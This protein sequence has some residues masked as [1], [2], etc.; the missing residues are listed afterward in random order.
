MRRRAAGA[1]QRLQRGRRL[2]RGRGSQAADGAARAGSGGFGRAALPAAGGCGAGR[3]T[4]RAAPD[5][6]CRRG[7]AGCRRRALGGLLRIA[8]RGAAGDDRRH[9]GARQDDDRRDGQEEAIGT[10]RR[11]D[12]IHESLHAMAET[13]AAIESAGNRHGK[14]GVLA[15]R[16]RRDVDQRTGQ[17]QRAGRCGD[18]EVVTQ[19]LGEVLE[20]APRPGVERLHGRERLDAAD[21]QDPRGIAPCHVR[22]LVRAQRQLLRPG[23]SRRGRAWAGTPRAAAGPWRAAPRDAAPRS[24]APTGGCRASRP[25]PRPRPRARRP[26]SGSGRGAGAAAARAATTSR[27]RPTRAAAAQPIARTVR[28]ARATRRTPERGRR[29]SRGQRGS[30]AGQALEARRA[31]ARR[32]AVPARRARRRRR[33]DARPIAD[34]ARRLP[35]ASASGK[36]CQRRP[37][38]G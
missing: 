23:P 33:R 6:G 9:E 2:R 25:R 18:G 37:G 7:S 30:R 11:T 4:A 8:R 22:E 3:F 20:T 5:G 14:N 10:L 36:T 1:G 19:A 34:G 31:R 16:P 21:E 15:D 32:C 27:A 24:G 13:A 29:S 38:P 17:P 26:R 28:Q 35:A 12:G